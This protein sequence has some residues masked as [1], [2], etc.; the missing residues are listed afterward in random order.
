[1]DGNPVVIHDWIDMPEEDLAVGYL[2]V[3]ETVH[4]VYHA[5]SVNFM[6]VASGLHVGRTYE[7]ALGSRAAP[8]NGV[9]YDSI[10]PSAS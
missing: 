3:A 5:Q 4:E 10:S 1:M 9:S 2:P 7:F 8:I 6:A